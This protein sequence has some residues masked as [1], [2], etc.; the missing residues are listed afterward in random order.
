MIPPAGI[1]HPETSIQHRCAGV[2]CIERS[3]NTTNGSNG[4]RAT[5]RFEAQ[6]RQGNRR[7]NLLAGKYPLNKRVLAVIVVAMMAFSHSPEAAEPDSA[8]V[9]FVAP[10]GQDR[11]AGTKESPFATLVR[12]RD[13]ARERGTNQVRR[14]V[15][16]GGSYYDVSLLLDARDARISIVAEPGEKP[17]LYGGRRVTG[18]EKD[19]DKFYAA[20]LPGVTVRTWDFRHLVV[21]NQMRPRARLPRT[22]EF[23]HLSRFGASWHSTVGGGFR[24]ADKPE[25]KM[26]LKYK[27]GDLG[28]WLD[29]NNAELTI[30]HQWD[31]SIVGL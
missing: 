7:I 9:F 16:R 6:L 8:E 12:A 14:I 29:V 5:C 30:F 2:I 15:V 3:N 24:G 18:W 10:D 19:G 17:M 11:N 22:G 1:Q 23:E 25:L 13:A 31:D 20:R 4:L 27:P 26:K 28:P 21:G